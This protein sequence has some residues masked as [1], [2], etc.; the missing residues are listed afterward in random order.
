MI[1]QVKKIGFFSALLLAGVFS[2]QAQGVAEKKANK[3]YDKYAYVDAI[4][5]YERIANKGYKNADMLQKLADAYYFNGK[6]IEANKWYAEL[7][8]G[9]YDDKGQEPISS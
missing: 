1:K 3:E 2:G 5:I 7:F 9:E 4:K 6:L 8:E